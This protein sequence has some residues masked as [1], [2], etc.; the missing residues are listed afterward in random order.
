MKAI[1]KRFL[2]AL[3]ALALCVVTVMCGWGNLSAYAATD[4]SAG[5]SDVLDDLGK[6]NS[7]K[8]ANYPEKTGD[9]SLQVIQLAEST[10]KEL[11]V[12]LYQ[13]SGQIKKLTASSINIST[14]VNDEISYFNYKLEL[15]NSSGVFF[16]YKVTDF[17]VKNEPT[18][19]YAISSIY[20]P[21][22][23]TIDNDA[24]HGNTV[25]EVNYEVS[26]QYC[27]S[28][29]N[30]NPYVNVVDIETI[31]VTDKF[32]GFVRYSGGHHF[33]TNTM[34]SCDSHFV[35]FNTD[36][37]IDNLIEADVFFTIQSYYK[38]W[39]AGTSNSET[40]GTKLD[41][42]VC[43]T[44][45][46]V[47]YNGGGWW[48][49][50]YSWERIE[51]VDE[52]IAEND[53]TQNVY[54]GAMFDVNV[55]NKITDEGKAALQD[56]QWVLRFFETEFKFQITGSAASG[57]YSDNRS[58]TI[59]GDVT[60]L[61]L[62]FETD[63]ITYNLGTID[64][65]QTGSDKPI[66]DETVDV[67][68]NKSGKWILGLIALILIIIL[69]GPIL[70]YIFQ[71]I[72]WVIS[73]P[74]KS[75]GAA[76]KKSKERREKKRKK[77]IEREKKK[78]RR[79]EERKRRESGELPDNVWTDDGNLKPKRKQKLPKHKPVEEMSRDEIESYLDGIDW[80]DPMWQ[81]VNGTK[82]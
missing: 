66:N 78:R 25:T 8:A 60:I 43:V 7:F 22:D 39:G 70:P 11:L 76:V 71:A 40:Y 38:E 81:N 9:Y 6:D 14:T 77:E 37:P 73:L 27:F 80:S 4:E 5:Y 61:R 29:I 20:R 45:K 33:W 34:P 49:G 64:N 35:A 74:F 67:T 59:V 58:F 2:Y 46:A 36:K 28:M 19:Y 10:E 51:T 26:K 32:V 42:T 16:K 24:E 31:T 82:N 15:L 72:F 13:P 69:L 54:S 52:F 18:R 56:K 30:G 62:K 57:T 17:T 23:E 68:V 79:A 12:Y 53:I 55:A 41:N 47:T 50:T 21:F 65:K 44:D 3:L 63:G 48:A 1:T 75:I